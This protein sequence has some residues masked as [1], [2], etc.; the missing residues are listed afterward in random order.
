MKHNNNGHI[1][2]DERNEGISGCECREQ[3]GDD[4]EDEDW[5]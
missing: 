1:G 2:N 5:A 3:R 4:D